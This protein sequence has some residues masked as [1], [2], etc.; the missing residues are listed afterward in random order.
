LIVS[1]GILNPPVRMMHEPG[2]RLPSRQGHPESLAGQL[3]IDPAVHCPT[4]YIPRKQIQHDSQV[5][6]TLPRPDIGNV[7]NPLMIRGRSRKIPSQSICRNRK[8]VIRIGRLPKA[9]FSPGLDS[10]IT[11]QTCHPFPTHPIS[12]HFQLRVDPWASIRLPVFLMNRPDLQNQPLAISAP[13]RFRS[14]PPRVITTPRNSHLPSHQRNR[15]SRLLR[16]NTSIPYWFSF[17]KKA[18][19]FF[20]KSRSIFNCVF[21][22]RSL[23]SSS[24]S[25]VVNAPEGP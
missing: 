23:R 16:V 11:H 14:L 15:I 3:P 5:Q 21:S 9:T 7:C 25:W 19:A 20:K 12:P 22:L 6:P 18:A 10:C 2:I 13:S 17:A 8:P 24:R 4:D 1:T